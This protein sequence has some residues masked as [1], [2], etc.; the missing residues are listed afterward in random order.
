MLAAVLAA[1]LAVLAVLVVIIIAAEVLT[2]IPACKWFE[3]LP[4]N[5]CKDIGCLMRI[6]I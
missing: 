5:I 6:K 1:L 3:L 2:Q 4:A